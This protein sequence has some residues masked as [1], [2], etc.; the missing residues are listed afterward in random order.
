MK[1]LYNQDYYERGVQLGISG[2]SNYRWLPEL[3]IPMCQTII[4]KLDIQK[5]DTILDYGCAKGYLVKAFNHLGYD[6]CGADLSNYAIESSD[7][8]IRHKL[9]LI[10]HEHTI[11]SIKK[12]FNFVI[13]KDVFEHIEPSVLNSVVSELSKVCKTLYVIIPLGDGTRYIIPEYEKDIT[14]IVREDE[15]W[16]SDMFMKNGFI[17]KEFSH[18]VPGIKDNWSHY[19][20]GNGFFV[21]ESVR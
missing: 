9:Y 4:K 21:L 17:I 16:W 12:Y 1:N 14:H 8:S 2:Y 18:R 6:C 11:S 3:T 20:K 13:S 15:N 5:G 10:E 19:P 7:S